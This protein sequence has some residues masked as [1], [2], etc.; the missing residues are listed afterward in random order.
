MR[1]SEKLIVANWKM[2]PATLRE[3]RALF[4]RIARASVPARA[5]IVLALPALYLAPVALRA[6]TRRISFAAQDVFPGTIGS[7]TGEISAPMLAS[8]GAR[9]SIVGHSERRALGET[10]EAVARKVEAALGAGLSVILC[11]GE[12][13]RDVQGT[14]LAYID[15]QI[16]S[17]LA[18]VVRAQLAQVVIAYEPIWAIGKSAE[19]AMKP[20][21]VHQMVVFVRKTLTALFGA[22]AARRVRVLYGGSVEVENAEALVRD[23]EVDGLLVGHASLDHAS[24]RGIVDAVAR[25]ARR[26]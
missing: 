1:F 3:A 5:E 11:I 14:Y 19:H 7:H 9:A 18:H 20:H 24:F 25:A 23:G 15:G 6:K 16:R 10:D 13:E 8:V 2:N 12:K 4:R 21:D 26:A 17:A 22:P